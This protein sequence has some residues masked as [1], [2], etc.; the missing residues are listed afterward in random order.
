[1]IVTNWGKIGGNPRTKEEPY[2]DEAKADKQIAKQIKQKMIKGYS[3]KEAAPVKA[4]A[5]TVKAEATPVKAEATPVKAK[6][7]PVKAKP[8]KECPE[9][10]FLIQRWSLHKSKTTKANKKAKAN[11]VKAK[12]T[13]ECPEGKVLNPAMV[14]A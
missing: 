5:N 14:A 9:G 7:T 1:M 6:A 12:A 13:K 3:S 4:E 10:K 2:E 11:T 8:P